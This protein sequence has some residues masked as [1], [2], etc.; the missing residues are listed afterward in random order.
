MF[1]VVL[2]FVS[3][4]AQRYS[5]GFVRQPRP[6]GVK[7]IEVS[8]TDLG[9]APRAIDWSNVTTAIKD[10]GSCG[11]CWAFSTIEG[12]E[13]ALYMSTGAEPEALSTEELVDC[14]NVDYGCDGG[15]IPTAARYLE[16]NGVASGSDYPDD[17]SKSGRTQSCTWDKQTVARLTDYSYA[18]APCQ[19]G[20]CSDMNEAV[21][22]AALA[23]SGPLSICVNS[24][25][26]Q[27]GDWADYTSGVLSGSCKAEYRLIDHCVQLVGYNKDA[28]TPYWKIRNSWGA[29]WGEDGFIRIP[30]GQDNTCCVACEA[31]EDGLARAAAHAAYWAPRLNTPE[32]FELSRLAAFVVEIRTAAGIGDWRRLA[33]AFAGGGHAARAAVRASLLE[34]LESSVVLPASPDELSFLELGCP[35]YCDEE[36][37][38][39]ADVAADRVVRAALRR[40]LDSGDRVDIIDVP[41]K[42]SVETAELAADVRRVRELRN[43]RRRGDWDAVREHFGTCIGLLQAEELAE[44][45]FEMRRRETA[46]ICLMSILDDAPVPPRITADDDDDALFDLARSTRRLRRLLQIKEDGTARFCQEDLVEA[47]VRATEVARDRVF[48]D[49][50]TYC[51]LTGRQARDFAPLV[52]TAIRRALEQGRETVSS[53]RAVRIFEEAVER[54][55]NPLVQLG[56][57]AEFIDP[58]LVCGWYSSPP[59]CK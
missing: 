42:T 11:S 35:S 46:K 23:K 10:Q 3:A 45:D 19:G 2:S 31:E 33:A 5:R 28:E 7:T 15:D 54:G 34:D 58:D 55:E 16:R 52:N 53:A 49:L 36:L 24:G 4:S 51:D 9:A 47:A 25:D 30:Y 57:L 12:V 44:I 27:S 8:A 1:F 40:V 21:L 29:A 38:L 18:I 6:E 32:A 41:A 20:D 37:E 39:L 17:S 48:Q 22:A 26:H 50:Q 56:D 43:A 59:S 13:S 14:D